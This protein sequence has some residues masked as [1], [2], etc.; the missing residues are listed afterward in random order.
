MYHH[1]IW[2]DPTHS[3]VRYG[4]CQEIRLMELGT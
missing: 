1:Q 2:D 3:I 4:Y